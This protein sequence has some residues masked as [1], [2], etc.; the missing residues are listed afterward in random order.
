MK[1][2]NHTFY[3]LFLVILGL[4]SF[5]ISCSNSI[6]NALTYKD[7]PQEQTTKYIDFNEAKEQI[8]CQANT[9]FE[10]EELNLVYASFFQKPF[11]MYKVKGVKGSGDIEKAVDLTRN[12]NKII[13]TSLRFKDNVEERPLYYIISFSPYLFFNKPKKENYENIFHTLYY[14]VLDKEPTTDEIK[15]KYYREELSEF[16]KTLLFWGETSYKG[17][18]YTTVQPLNFLSLYY[19][20]SDNTNSDGLFIEKNQRTLSEFG[21]KLNTFSDLELDDFFFFQKAQFDNQNNIDYLQI[22]STK[23]ISMI[24]PPYTEITTIKISA[25]MLE[26]L[27]SAIDKCGIIKKMLKDMICSVSDSEGQPCNINKQIFLSGPSSTFP[28]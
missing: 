16:K 5:S 15:T 1:N 26:S 9:P 18:S 24:F 14:E 11:L 10:D 4:S 27:T 22:E 21:I 25:R 6:H 28:F 3:W 13:S 19:K 12:N 17:I 23:Q 7:L 20:L 2:T 8:T